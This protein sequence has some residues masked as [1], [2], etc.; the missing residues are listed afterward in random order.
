MTTLL[1]SVV[2]AL[3]VL[4]GHMRPDDA[5]VAAHVDEDW[6]IAKWGAD[7][8]AM[9]RRDARQVEFRAAVRLCDLL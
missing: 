6:Q 2:L 1:G 3:G 7:V 5:W 8:E 4:H 9:R